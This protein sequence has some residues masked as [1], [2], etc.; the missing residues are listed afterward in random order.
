LEDLLK[1]HD[2]LKALKERRRREEIESS[3]QD[4]K[5]LEDILETLLKHSPTLSE[6]FL[7]GNRATNPFK[8]KKVQAEE[9]PFD[10]K[11][12]PTFFKFK[13]K[14]Y[15]A[16]VT[17]DCHINMRCR[18]AFETDAANDY[19][20]RKIEAGTFSLQL[21]GEQIE[22]VQVEDYSLNLQNGIATLNLKLPA[23]CRVGDALR[24]EATTTDPSRLEPFKN[25]F[26]IQVKEAAETGGGKGPR[27]KPPTEQEGVDRE[28]PSGIQLPKWKAVHESEWQSQSPPFD[29]YTALRIKDAGADENGGDANGK[30]I[31]DFF[32]N[33]DNVHLKRYLKYEHKAEQLEQVARTRFELGLM[34]SGLALIHRAAQRRNASGEAEEDVEHQELDVEKQVEEVTRALAPFLLPMI[35]ALGAL[36]AEN[37]AVTDASG[38]AT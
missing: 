11:R 19:F 31:Y 22:F 33:V 17:R 26:A 15:G 24:L 38:E 1:H 21:T 18:I 12:F 27:R 2:G 20:S 16:E 23:A 37:V 32:I 4:S 14:E 10:G 9:K 25:V 8:P 7:F 6:L 28:I 34:L 30:S 29:Q 13:G 3:L 5:P 35:D 36:D